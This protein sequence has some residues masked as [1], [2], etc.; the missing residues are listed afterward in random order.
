MSGIQPFQTQEKQFRT[1]R[2]INKP[3]FFFFPYSTC[4]GYEELFIKSFVGFVDTIFLKTFCMKLSCSAWFLHHVVEVL[5]DL[6]LYV[7][8]RN[9]FKVRQLS[10]T[11]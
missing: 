4:N 2:Y 6:P 8:L 5:S 1:M 10:K 3:T 7:S 11:P 9:H